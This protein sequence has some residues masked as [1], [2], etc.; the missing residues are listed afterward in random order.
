M[1]NAFGTV[2]VSY[3]LLHCLLANGELGGERFKMSLFVCF[4]VPVIEDNDE[5]KSVIS[6]T[7]TG[8]FFKSTSGAQKCARGGLVSDNLTNVARSHESIL[9]WFRAE[10]SLGPGIEKTGECTK[11]HLNTKPQQVDLKIRQ[12]KGAIS[13]CRRQN[14]IVLYERDISRVFS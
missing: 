2:A 1:S 13:H 9:D 4:I 3:S 8:L 11:L 12:T 5:A 10:C 14:Y 7:L 6:G